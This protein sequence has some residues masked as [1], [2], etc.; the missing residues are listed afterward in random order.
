MAKKQKKRYKYTETEFINKVCAN[1]GLC[2]P[3]VSHFCYY[4]YEKSP[5]K[6]MKSSYSQLTG[7]K[8]WPSTKSRSKKK[9]KEIFCSLQVCGKK[10]RKKCNNIMN[11]LNNFYPSAMVQIQR[12][13]GIKDILGNLGNTP[14]KTIRRHKKSKRKQKKAYIV[15]SKPTFFCSDN[16]EWKDDIE[17]ALHGKSIAQGQDNSI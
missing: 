12:G 6:F 11:C 5:R 7:I 16:K 2:P 15:E 14:L 1:C 3:D 10:K 8:N 17:E 9:F 13:R 4:I